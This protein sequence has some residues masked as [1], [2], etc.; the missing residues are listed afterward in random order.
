M[1]VGR[2]GGER[3]WRRGGGGEAVSGM[4]RSSAWGVGRG[5]GGEAVE[6]GGVRC[7][8]SMWREHWAH[9][10]RRRTHSP[11]VEQGRCTHALWHAQARG[12]ASGW[13]CWGMRAP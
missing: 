7:R 3:R 13:C 5:G 6:E 1:R 4:G 8:G 12:Q 9:R 10:L 11:E 2:G